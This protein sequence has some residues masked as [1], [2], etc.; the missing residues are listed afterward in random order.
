M[1]AA[2]YASSRP[3]AVGWFL[4]LLLA[5]LGQQQQHGVS[6]LD[7]SLKSFTCDQTLP[8]FATDLYMSCNG[9]AQCTLGQKSDLFGICK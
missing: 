3:V 2:M 5:L 6:A 9:N 8:I 7:I 1:V 4:L